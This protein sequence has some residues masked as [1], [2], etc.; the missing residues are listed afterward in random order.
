MSNEESEGH[1]N[2]LG[3]SEITTR[4]TV[5]AKKKRSPLTK[6]REER[7]LFEKTTRERL[8]HRGGQGEWCCA[9]ERGGRSLGYTMF[10][11]SST[12]T[13]MQ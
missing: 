7:G 2:G 3:G 11:S 4:K 9:A 10:S 13:S 5:L 1:S 6:I 12:R 8:S